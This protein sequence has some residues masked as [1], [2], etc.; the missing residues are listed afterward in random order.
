MP[1]LLLRTTDA[2]WRELVH[3]YVPHGPTVAFTRRDTRSP[4]IA[5]AAAIA[6]DAGFATAVRSPGG[7]M[8]AYDEGAVV[9]DHVNGRDSFALNAD[10]HARVLRSLGVDARVGEVEGE[11]CPGEFSVNVGGRFKVVGSAQR[12]TPTG[13]LFSTVV[14]VATSGRV[15]DVIVAVSEALGYD[16]QESTIGGLRDVRSDLTPAQVAAALADDYR[17]RLGTTDEPLDPW[18]AGLAAE[19]AEAPPTDVPFDVDAWARAATTSS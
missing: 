7:R 18:V 5:R 4:G 10:H 12:I 11:Y 8:V 9:V 15:H 16:L 3:V 1:A 6:H 2:P 13:S 14:Q 19:A 17:Q